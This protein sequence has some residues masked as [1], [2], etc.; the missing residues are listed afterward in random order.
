MQVT[1]TEFQDGVELNQACTLATERSQATLQQYAQLITNERAKGLFDILL[2]KYDTSEM[3]P[4]KIADAKPNPVM[5]LDENAGNASN[6]TN[7]INATNPLDNSSAVTSR[8]VGVPALLVCVLC[9]LHT[10]WITG[11]YFFPA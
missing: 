11:Y 1:R 2:Q 9:A 7:A 5:V 10:S 3:S 8:V 6:A 4:A